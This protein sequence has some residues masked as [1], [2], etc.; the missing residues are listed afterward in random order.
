MKNACFCLG[1]LLLPYFLVAQNCDQVEVTITTQTSDWGEELSWILINEAGEQLAV[2]ENG[3][4]D[5]SYETVICLSDGCYT[6][7]AADSYGDGWNGGE[8]NISFLSETLQYSLADGSSGIFYFGINESDCTPTILGCLDPNALNYDPSATVDDGSCMTLSDVIAVQVFDT[9]CYS[10]PKDNRINWVIQNRGDVNPDYEFSSAEEFSEAFENDLLL[11]FTL[12]HDQ[13]QIPYAQYKDFFNLYSV[14]WPDAPSDQ[15]W[16]SFPIIQNMRNEIFLP[17]ANDETGWATWFSTT[18]SGGGGGAGLIREQ[19]VGDGKMYGMGWETFLHEFGHTMPGLLDEYSASGEWSNGQ[20]W[21]TPNTTGFL[22]LDEIP[23]RRWIEPSTPIPTPYTEEYLDKYG[24]FE[25]ALTN[26]FGCHRPTARGCY[27][28]AGGFGEGYGLELCG[29]CRQRVIC[30]LYQYVNVIENPIPAQPNLTVSGNETITFSSDV[31][32]PVPNTQK[33]EWFLNGRLIA[34]GVEEVD[35]TFGA[36][37]RYE[38]IF[39]VTDTNTLVKYDPKFDEIYPKPYR[40][41]KWTIEQSDIGTYDLTAELMSNVLDCSGADN[42]LVTF[43]IQG[44]IAPYN[45]VYKDQIVEQPV[46]NLPKGEHFFTIVDASGCSIEKS[47]LIEENPFLDL[48]LCSEWTGDS[49]NLS[50]ATENYDQSQ[51]SFVWS[52]GQNSSAI[53][54]LSDGIYSVSVTTADGCTRS[55]SVELSTFENPLIVEH[56]SFPS[57]VGKNTGSIYLDITGGIPPYSITWEDKLNNDVTDAN[58]NNIIASGTTWGHLPQYAFDDDLDEK[59]LHAVSTAAWI[60]YVLPEGAVINYYT[61]TSA[62]DVP[63]RDPKDW[64]F[65]GSN[66]GNNWIDLD[67]RTNED[68]PQRFQ[69][70]GF[71]FEN[72]TAYQYYRLFVQANNGDIATQLQQLEFIGTQSNDKFTINEQAKDLSR[73]FELA[74]GAYVYT[75]KDANQTAQHDTVYL[76]YSDPFIAT[77][78]KVTQDGDCRVKIQAPNSNYTYYWLS[79]EEGTD[80]LAIGNNFTPPSTGNYYIAAVDNNSNSMSS[81]RKGFAVILDHAPIVETNMDNE[82]VIIDP[83]PDME[84]RWYKTEDCSNL[85]ATGNSFT[86][87]QGT[88]IYFAAAKNTAPLPSPINPNDLPGLIIRMD[89]SDLNGDGMIDDPAPPTASTYDWD[90]TNGNRWSDGSW[91]AYRSNHQNGLGIADFA[92]IWLQSL[93]QAENNYQTIMMAYEENPISFPETAP[94]FGLSANIPRHEDESQLFSNN[95]PNTTLEGTTFLNGQIV[96][97]LSTANPLA[98]C[99]L[100]TRMTAVSTANI[101]GTDTRWEGKLGELLLWDYA[102]SDEE[103]LGVSEFLRKKWMSVADLESPKVPIF[104]E[105]AV[106]NQ[107]I[108]PNSEIS[109]FPN[110]TEHIVTVENLPPSGNIQILNLS[111]QLIANTTFHSDRCILRLSNLASGTYILRIVDKENQNILSSKLVK[112]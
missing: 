67:Q 65:Q 88:G 14:F 21:E 16:W 72:T 61:I 18:K 23:W 108:L 64:V 52:T 90:F 36:C 30:F 49:W 41:F 24:A 9:I 89:A 34:E 74:A 94:F 83:K 57:E 97:P 46:M 7:E 45:I 95:T 106:Q 62:D 100:G 54:F 4:S 5:N 33:Y 87:T 71:L 53:S 15:E 98:F 81:N 75:V 43:D 63:A 6:L 32:K 35:I 101:R 48:Q 8:V 39:A 92:T 13:A 102:L 26:F 25:G 66:D 110:P 60:G 78:L 104:W 11:A 12:G 51:L 111:G 1:L 55:E 76:S 105:A 29:P 22:T 80:I 58:T 27:M 84:Y 56:L 96:D 69:K 17:W 31:L 68:F 44:G 103:M 37:D 107:T 20:C 109:F 91:F 99:V 112:Q 77:G 93:E 70:R 2:F 28:G 10:G 86:P 82:L 73:R 79:D 42:G 59:W 40:E 38:L 50:V 85:L 3:I 19:R 47:I